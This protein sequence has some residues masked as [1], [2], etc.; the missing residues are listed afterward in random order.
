MPDGNFEESKNV[1][2]RPSAVVEGKRRD[3]IVLLVDAG[4]STQGLKV[5]DRRPY[6]KNAAKDMILYVQERSRTSPNVCSYQ[7]A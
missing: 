7:S 6:F 3:R 5:K 2:C 1:A 4:S